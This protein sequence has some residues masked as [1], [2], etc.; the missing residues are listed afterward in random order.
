MMWRG[1]Y[2]VE[3]YRSAASLGGDGKPQKGKEMWRLSSHRSQDS[4]SH[5]HSAE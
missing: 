1:G 4:L 5:H 2:G 3:V